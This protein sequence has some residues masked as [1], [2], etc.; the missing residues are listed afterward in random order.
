MTP[1]RTTTRNAS[2]I[3]R[4]ALG[5]DLRTMLIGEIDSYSGRVTLQPR[6]RRPGAPRNRKAG[7][8]IK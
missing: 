3:V 6:R 5:A 2:R 8:G 7:A 1:L 4:A